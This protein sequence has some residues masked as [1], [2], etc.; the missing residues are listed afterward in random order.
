MK[1]AA[2]SSKS[3]PKK[4]KLAEEASLDNEIPVVATL[5][6]AAA[7]EKARKEK[8]KEMETSLEELL[9]GATAADE[10]SIAAKVSE[11]NN[12]SKKQKR[13][14]IGSSTDDNKAAYAGKVAAI[15]SVWRDEDDDEF[16]V[17][18]NA[19]DR[20][21]KLKKDPSKS[22]VSATEYAQLLNER[23]GIPHAHTG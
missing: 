11:A 13:R 17:N 9:F 6:A 18:L 15:G 22:K 2:S 12:H 14:R 21:K 19:T 10:R 7:R 16:E 4:K 5:T 23:Y 8:E 1:K 20:T 3:A